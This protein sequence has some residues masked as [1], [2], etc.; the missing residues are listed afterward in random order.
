MLELSY[1]SQLVTTVVY[2]YTVWLYKSCAHISVTVDKDAACFRL[3]TGSEHGSTYY[4]LI[5][6][7]NMSVDAWYTA[8]WV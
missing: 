7:V 1:Y 3:V 2:I 6:S 4:Q 5:M 8:A